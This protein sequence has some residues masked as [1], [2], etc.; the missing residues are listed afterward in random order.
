MNC[1]APRFFAFFVFAAVAALAAYG[2]ASSGTESLQ[3]D[4]IVRVVVGQATPPPPGSFKTDLAAINSAASD[5]A[6]Q[7]PPKKHGFGNILG[8]VL[9]GQSPVDAAAGNVADN[10]LSN[11][12][13]GMLGSLN[14]YT[15]FVRRG[16]LAR[17][18]FYNGWQRV[19][20]AAGQTA[21]INKFDQ[22]QV[23]VLDLKAKTYR[24]TDTSEH[25]SA[26]TPE[27]VPHPKHEAPSKETPEQPGT[28]VVDLRLDNAV[29]GPQVLDGIPTTGYRSKVTL[30]MTQAT[31][32]CRNGSFSVAS[33]Q[34]FS[35]FDE[36]RIAYAATSERPAARVPTDPRAM[37]T[38]GG[39]KPTF[40]VHNSGSPPPGGRFMMYS[41]VAMQPQDASS[42][43]ANASSFAFITERGN[44]VSLP[45]STVASLFEVRP[46]SFQRNDA[47]LDRRLATSKETTCESA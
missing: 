18:T 7:P 12:M 4:E 37:V 2:T 9:S 28:A 17:Y 38:Q 45:T 5:Q 35:R 22:H 34:Y 29:L 36:P 33:S 15:A 23:I 10:A 30:A 26:A 20:D 14:A 3:Y 27:Q 31:G 32:S 21:T 41:N 46:T 39:C 47:A 6:A 1:K 19:D 8:A 13:G 43:S 44:V 24:T 40:T 16:K 25:T 42:S 11:A